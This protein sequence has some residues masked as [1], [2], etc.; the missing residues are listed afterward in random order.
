MRPGACGRSGTAV[1]R[2]ATEGHAHGARS[3]GAGVSTRAVGPAA[4]WR[5]VIKRSAGGQ[6]GEG[7]LT[8]AC[9]RAQRRA[10]TLVSPGR[11]QQQR[12]GEREVRA[13]AGR[14]G[15]LLSVPC[16]LRGTCAA[17]NSAALARTS[18]V[19]GRDVMEDTAPSTVSCSLT[20]GS[21]GEANAPGDGQLA[22]HWNE[23]RR[24]TSEQDRKARDA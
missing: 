21:P 18:C 20:S 12:P 22:V 17:P 9:T 10:R 13:G 11:P 19:A 5:Q 24:S 1:G 7:S 15:P 4:G 3:V 6:I 14:A 2:A 23:G 8:A 16:P